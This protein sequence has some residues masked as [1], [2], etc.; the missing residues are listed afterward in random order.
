MKLGDLEKFNHTCGIACVKNEVTNE[1]WIVVYAN[2]FDKSLLEDGELGRAVGKGR[3]KEEALIDAIK[4]F[5][6][7]ENVYEDSLA[8][9]DKNEIYNIRDMLDEA[10]Q[11]LSSKMLTNQ[12]EVILPIKGWKYNPDNSISDTDEYWNAT[13]FI[14]SQGKA[15]EGSV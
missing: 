13:I 1:D 3:T 14:D 6:K 5:V 9:N 10:I 4:F 7:R 15:V 12:K 8:E 2:T 11:F